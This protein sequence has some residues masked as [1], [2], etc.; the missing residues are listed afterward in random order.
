MASYPAIATVGT[1]ILSLLADARPKPDFANAQFELYQSSDFESPM[2]E[3][4]SL[5]LYRVTINGTVRNPVARVDPTGKRRRPPLP[6]DLYFMM[7]AWGRTAEKQQFLLAWAMQQLE[8][9]PILPG[10]LLNSFGPEPEVFRPDETVELICDP[11]PVQD[12]VSIWENL[13]SSKAKMQISVSYV[14][15]MVMIESSLELV[16]APWVQTRTFRAAQQRTP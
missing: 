9:N 1:A 4:I 13:K 2:E 7:T 5:F 16:E 8:D 15:R 6:L 14:A 11:M 12:M 3:G 10:S